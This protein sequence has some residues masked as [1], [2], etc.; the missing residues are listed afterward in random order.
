MWAEE[1][2]RYP[3]IAEMC[4]IEAVVQLNPGQSASLV[5]QLH[6]FRDQLG[7]TPA[8]LKENGWQIGEKAR[9]ETPKT[10]ARGSSRTRLKAVPK[11]DRRVG[12]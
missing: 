4:L 2:W 10:V 8:G 7:L 11:S 5:S 6:R 1:S 3:V 9:E 12:S